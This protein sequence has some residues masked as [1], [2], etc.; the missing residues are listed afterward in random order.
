MNNEFDHVEAYKQGM[1]YENFM[2]RAFKISHSRNNGVH[3]SNM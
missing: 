1:S 3:C 2:S